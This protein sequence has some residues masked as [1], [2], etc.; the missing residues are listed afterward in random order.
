MVLAP[1]VFGAFVEDVDDDGPGD[2]GLIVVRGVVPVEEGAW[3]WFFSANPT[4]N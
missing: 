3:R 2:V 1:L 4:L